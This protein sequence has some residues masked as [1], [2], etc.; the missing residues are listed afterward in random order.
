MKTDELLDRCALRLAQIHVPEKLKQTRDVLHGLSYDISELF[1]LKEGD[2]RVTIDEKRGRTVD[3]TNLLN[4]YKMAFQKASNDLRL[5]ESYVSN[6]EEYN[7]FFCDEVLRIRL[8]E[9]K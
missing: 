5:L 2:I 3:Y 4:R 7:T 8:E 6:V 9:N 1:Q